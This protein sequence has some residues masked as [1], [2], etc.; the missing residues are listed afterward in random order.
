MKKYEFTGKTKKIKIHA[1]GKYE[2]VTLHRIRALRSFGDVKA[3]ALGGWIEKERNLS[4]QKTAWV[5]DDAE[6]WG[7]SKVRDNARVLNKARVGNNAQI[8]DHAIV[9]NN[10]CVF[11]NAIIQNFAI[12]E[13][14]A[15]VG[16]DVEISGCT[17]VSHNAQ[18]QGG[19]KIDNYSKIY[20]NAAINGN[21][22]IGGSVSI[23]GYTV[24]DGNVMIN[25][26]GSGVIEITGNAHLQDGAK[27]TD[28]NHMFVI[29]PI[30]SR[31]DYTTFYK[32]KD[33]GIT[34]SCGCFTGDIETFLER[35]IETH[36][37]S[38]H[39]QVYRRATEIAILQI[40]R[41][42]H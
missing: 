27:I 15:L 19:A 16:D 9:M 34:V 13:N 20:D 3:G 33:N 42:G 14:N 28:R 5:D 35:V 39:A 37:C 29:G 38:K 40:L 41:S 1:C 26:N 11:S 36:G 23:H 25:S 31:N 12:I 8:R 24:I 32:N 4:H 7:T 10:A 22:M 17:R 21:V 18:I 2:T 6:V 30:G